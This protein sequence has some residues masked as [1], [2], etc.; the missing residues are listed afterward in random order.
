MT[1]ASPSVESTSGPGLPARIIG[2][3]FSPRETFAAVVARPRWFGVMAI[4]LVVAAACTYV[5]MSSPDLQEAMID[6]QVR[7]MT[8]SGNASDAQIA[9][10]ETFIGYL[11]VIYAGVILFLGPV[12]AAIFAGIFMGIFTTLLGGS[13]TFKQVYAI[14]AHAGVISTLQGMFVAAMTMAGAR[15]SGV[16]PPGANLGVFVPMLEET[17][18][19]ALMLSNIDLFLLWWLVALSIGLSVLY[20]RRTGPIATS[21]IGIYVIIAL[22]IAFFRS[23]S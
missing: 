23:G 21:L 9:G 6:Q 14:G 13:G 7:A 3:L 2:V 11:P 20:K 1:T 16:T 5:T 17:S 12:F 15:P 10:V 22:V 18:F 4:T 19:V 8:A